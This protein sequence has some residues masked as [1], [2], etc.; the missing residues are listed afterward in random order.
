[1]SNIVRSNELAPAVRTLLGYLDDLRRT[2]FDDASTKLRLVVNY[3]QKDEV[4]RNLAE[5]LRARV[6]N[7]QLGELLAAETLH[8]PHDPR[9]HMGLAYTLLYHIKQG[10]KLELRELLTRP[11]F[12]A[13]A[14]MDGRWERFKV[15]LVDALV[16]NGEKVLRHVE[17]WAAAQPDGTLVDPNDVFLAAL[18][19]LAADAGPAPAA[20]LTTPAKAATPAAPV[21]ATPTA[22]RA[23]GEP[24]LPDG[25]TVPAPLEAATG[26]LRVEAALLGLELSK[27]AP[28]PARLEELLASFEPA[29]A[30]LRAGLATLLGPALV[31]LARGAAP[32]PVEWAE[33]KAKPKTKSVKKA[34]PA[35]KKPETKRRKS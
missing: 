2:K 33:T 5:L 19:T 32:A 13:G 3:W 34:A 23:S 25:V 4:A 28:S 18:A 12:A 1:M 24:P 16:V 9:D 8:L 6:S 14:G 35:K 22:P 29:P 15:Q 11:M 30:S 17:G 27:Q 31:R 10:W 7:E 21:A 26:D 20:T